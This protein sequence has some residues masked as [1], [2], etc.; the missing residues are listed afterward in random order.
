[1][2]TVVNAYL[3]PVLARYIGKL[4]RELSADGLRYPVQ[5]MTCAGGTIFPKDVTRRAVSLVNGGPVGGLVAARE[6]GLTL[7]FQDA[8]T[9]DMG[10]TS[11]DVGIIHGGVIRTEASTFVSQGTPVQLEAA[12][13]DT[14]GAGV[15][16]LVTHPAL[17]TPALKERY[18]WNYEWSTELDALISPRI[19]ESVRDTGIRLT[20]FSEC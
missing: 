11:F 19:L 10:G 8:I 12:K 20:R 15:T 4:A 18:G 2:T 13:V 3:A 16:E 17:G 9:T 14:I 7:G 1:M 6:L 5:L